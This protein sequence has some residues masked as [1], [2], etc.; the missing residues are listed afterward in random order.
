M[1]TLK[2]TVTTAA[3]AAI[4][5][6]A[7]LATA[8]SASGAIPSFGRKTAASI[9]S[10]LPDAAFKIDP[11]RGIAINNPN[12]RVRI[13]DLTRFPAL[14][15]QDVQSQVVRVMLRAGKSF[16]PHSHPRGTETFNALR[17]VF[18]VTFTF[19]GL[20]PRTVRNVIRAGQSTVFPQGLPHTTRC[21]S[22]VDC[23]FL[24]TFNTADPGLVPSA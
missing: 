9:R 14:A 11:S 6:V 1:T 4:A 7:M 20:T 13:A 2:A 23:T 8:A 19:E 12:F 21:I 17:G 15:G 5:A 16:I 24:S 22:K 18:E 3:V 10:G